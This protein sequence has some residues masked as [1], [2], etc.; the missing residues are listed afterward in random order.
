MC[1][2]IINLEF[3]N[4]YLQKAHPGSKCLSL[5]YESTKKVMEWECEF[6]HIW[7]AKFRK[8]LYGGTWCPYCAKKFRYK[9]Y[10]H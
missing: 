4:D 6:H 5:F 9:P 1:N 10:S 2:N 7:K 8:I 3:I